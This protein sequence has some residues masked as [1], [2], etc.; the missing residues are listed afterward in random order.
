MVTSTPGVGPKRHGHVEIARWALQQLVDQ[1]NRRARQAL[2]LIEHEQARRGVQF[3]GA[4]HHSH[5]LRGRRRR[6]GIVR[7]ECTEIQPALLERVGEVAPEHVRRIV[8]IQRDPADDPP[9]FPGAAGDVRQ[10]RRLA[11]SGGRLQHRE[12]PLQHTLE[13]LR[14][15][16][17]LTYPFGHSAAAPSPSGTSPAR[18]RRSIRHPR[19]IRQRPTA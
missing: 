4:G 2:D 7:A 3:D 15:D 10:Q 5:L 19:P 13:A 17:R 12:S 16:G 14:R 1:P 8:V 11:E 18:P 9:F 6:P